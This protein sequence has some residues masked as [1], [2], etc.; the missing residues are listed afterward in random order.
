MNL[1][2]PT[3]RALTRFHA[4]T[5]VERRVDEALFARVR[6]DGHISHS[7][8][9]KER[10]KKSITWVIKVAAKET[11]ELNLVGVALYLRP[12]CRYQEEQRKKKWRNRS[13]I[14]FLLLNGCNPVRLATIQLILSTT[15]LWVPDKTFSQQQLGSPTSSLS[16]L[17][18]LLEWYQ[19][20]HPSKYSVTRLPSVHQQTDIFRF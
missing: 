4:H 18:E 20:L 19:D 12:R 17:L 9:K 16:L 8:K 13:T 1:I 2:P 14:L 3:C 10:E 15:Y 5:I 6:R 11:D 7:K